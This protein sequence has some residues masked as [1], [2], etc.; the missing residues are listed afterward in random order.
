MFLL[1]CSRV[2]W[3]IRQVHYTESSL[4][5]YQISIYYYYISFSTRIHTYI[6]I[7]GT[8]GLH[9]IYEVIWCQYLIYGKKRARA[10][11]CVYAKCVVCVCCKTITMFWL[12]IESRESGANK[13]G[14]AS[15]KC[16]MATRW[17]E[18][19]FSFS[20]ILLSLPP[21]KKLMTLINWINVGSYYWC[22]F[23]SIKTAS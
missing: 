14:T 23:I 8:H 4:N 6:R 13:S 21:E 16:R 2:R 20:H 1:L 11:V 10:R 18:T 12:E 17:L 5:E 7:F 22:A 19:E 9:L 3:W 15:R